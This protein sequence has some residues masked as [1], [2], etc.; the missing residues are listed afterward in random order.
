M[1]YSGGTDQGAT[2]S[3]TQIIW[4]GAV[5]SG[6]HVGS[7]GFQEVVGLALATQLNS[8]GVDFVG[9]GGVVSGATISGGTLEIASGGSTGAG[10]VTFA[11]SGG[12][13]L[14]LDA[15]VSF[16]G[17]VAGFGLPDN[18]DLRDIAYISGT[19]TSS[20]VEAGNNLSGT[21]TVSTSGTTANIT[22]L[23]QYVAAQ[24]HLTSD[25][26]GGTLVTDPP[27]AVATDQPSFLTQPRRG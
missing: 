4:G 14:Q 10:A 1:V 26:H 11:T 3:G 13:T 12:G 18:L 6:A 23:G 21:L 24:F 17:L 8:G 16:G 5:A 7:G 27:L 15:S 25:G 19:T 20:F 2:I 9:S 22:L